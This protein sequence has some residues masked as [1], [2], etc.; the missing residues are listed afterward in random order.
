MQYYVA[1]SPGSRY[2]CHRSSGAKSWVFDRI[3]TKG[4]AI[5]NPTAL[6]Y[7][8]DF[9]RLLNASCRVTVDHQHVRTLAGF[10]RAPPRLLLQ[11]Q[12]SVLRRDRDRL[13]RRQTSFDEQLK[14]T[15]QTFSIEV[16]RIWR[17]R[18]GGLEN[19]RIEQS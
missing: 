12:G 8:I 6:H 5:E 19:S 1:R 3:E 7:D 17:V 16:A 2:D 14:L 18:T 15:M 11:Q 10:E 9:T 13:Q 4:L